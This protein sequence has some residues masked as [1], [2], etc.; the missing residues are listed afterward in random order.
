[1]KILN[2]I[3]FSLVSLA[4]SIFSKIL[5]KKSKVCEEC[6]T[7]LK[8]NSEKTKANFKWKS[9]EKIIRQN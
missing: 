9:I 6:N 2:L 1:M 5:R 3:L 8:L 4:L 7:W